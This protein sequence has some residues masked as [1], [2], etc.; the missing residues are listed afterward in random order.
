MLH[1]TSIAL[2]ALVL[3]TE[4]G[5]VDPV[6]GPNEADV[7][8]IFRIGAD[9]FAYDL[10]PIRDL[11]KCRV[12]RLRFRSP[13]PSGDLVNDRVHADYFQP[14][15]PGRRPAVVVLHILGADFALSRYLSLRLA[16]RGVASLFVRLPYY[17]ERREAGS[18]RRFLSG[19]LDRSMLAMRQ[20]ICDVRRALDWLAARPELDPERLG[21]AGISLGGI[22]SA[23]VAGVDPKVDR[24]ALLL[25]GGGLDSILWDMPEAEARRYRSAWTTLGKT[26]EDL[27]AI[28]RPF[29]PLTY[30]GGMKGKRVLMIAG[31]VDEVVP[32]SAAEALWEVAGRPSI[33]WY[34]CGHYSA[35]AYLLPAI[36]RTADFLAE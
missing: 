31:N 24:A 22:V 27:A 18:D 33:V 23:V 34:D 9:G 30:A 36:E 17:G 20:G 7:P 11:R 14:T 29:D 26:R 32:P 35:A 15:S 19:D 4:S 3:L 10:L 16:D 5:R 12:A 1:G 13:L 8:A 6:S 25:A 21:V 28:T 2:G